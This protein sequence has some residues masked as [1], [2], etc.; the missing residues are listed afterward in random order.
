LGPNQLGETPEVS[1]GLAG[2]R[3]PGR[4]TKFAFF[5]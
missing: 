3:T 5:A 1:S 4:Y 2:R